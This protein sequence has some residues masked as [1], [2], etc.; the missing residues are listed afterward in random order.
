VLAVVNYGVCERAIVL[1]LI[2]FTSYK[3]SIN[4]ITN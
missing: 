3:E 4:L 2:V 1:E